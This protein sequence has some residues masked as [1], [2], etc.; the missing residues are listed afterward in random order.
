MFALSLPASCFLGSF[1]W[2]SQVPPASDA[3]K[4]SF[5]LSVGWWKFVYNQICRNANIMCP[6]FSLGQYL[7]VV[8]RVYWITADSGNGNIDTLD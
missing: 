7:N 3:V 1:T 4:F 2:L 5:Y 8:C 6:L